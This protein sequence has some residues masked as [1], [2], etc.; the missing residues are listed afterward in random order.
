MG[1]YVARRLFFALFVL[2]G[3]VSVIFLVLRLVPGDPAVVLLGPDANPDQIAALRARMGLDQPIIVQY[4]IYMRDVVQLDFGDSFRFHTDAMDHVLAHLPNSAQLAVTSVCLALLVGFPLGIIAALKA[5]TVVD[6]VIS[7]FS[8]ATQ[9]LPNFWVGI[10]LILVFA[11][12]LQVLPSYGQGSWQHL[13]LPSVTLALPFL[14]ILVRLTRSGLLEVIHE[15]Y[16]QTARAKGLR[17]RAVIF[18]HALRNALIPVITVVGLQ[19]GAL[20]G[21]TVIVET[22]FAW[23]GV[24]R[25]LIESISHR[26]YGVVQAAILLIAAAFVVTNLVVDLLYGYLD[27][28][29]RL[30][31]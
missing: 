12:G 29:V 15:G 6:R 16:V 25:V 5:N 30:A 1:A 22:V 3:A 14:A 7:V 11:R 13:V 9:S 10:V 4:G 19:F 23:P 28:R 31:G 27:P 18:P 20:L 21:G 26:D 2:W 8:L 17:E 24:G